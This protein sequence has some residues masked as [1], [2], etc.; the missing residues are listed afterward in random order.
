MKRLKHLFIAALCILSSC[1][2]KTQDDTQNLAGNWAFRLDSL[3]MGVNEKWYLDSLESTVTLPGSLNTNGIGDE[4]TKD[5]PWT[6]SIWNKVWYESDFYAKYRTPDNTKVVFW[7]TPDKYYVGAAWYQKEINIPENWKDQSVEL[8]LE[9]CHWETTLWVDS[10]EIGTQNTLSL[11]HRYYLEN[12]TAGKHILTL[13]VDNRTK[14]INPGADAHSISDN[15]QSNWNGIIGEI[16]INAVP[17]TRI[18]NVRIEPLFDQKKIKVQYDITS[19]K[20]TQGTLTLAVNPVDRNGKKL[21]KFAQTVS[22]DTAN[23]IEVVY[24]MTDDFER[25]D[26]FNPNLYTLESTLTTEFGSQTDNTQFG[27]RE[28]STKGTRI[29]VNNNPVFFRGTLECCIFPKTG[30]PPTDEDEWERIMNICKDYGL[31]HIRFHSWCPPTAAF[32]VADRLGMY[33]YVECGSWASDIGSGLGV[34]N[35]IMEESHRIVDE[36]GNHPSFCLFSYG[37]EPHGENR[38]AYLREFVKHWKAADNRFLYTT[39]AGWPEIEENDWQCVQAPRI[40]R[41]GEGVKSVI[42]G[43]EPS[44]MYDWSEIISKT[45]PTISHEI[46]QW[47]VYPNLK[48]REKYTGVFKAKNFDIFEDRLE[49]NGILHLADKFF[50]ASGKLQTLCYKADIE[51]ALRTEGQAGFQLL[52]LH[53]FPGQGSA[54][55][56]VVDPFWDS[57]PYVSAEEY[58]EFCNEVVPLARMERLVYNSLDTLTANIEVSQFSNS[59]LV[60]PKVKWSIVDTTEKCL[61]SGEFTPK[62]ITQGKLNSIGKISQ[63]LETDTPQQ[64]QLIVSVDNWINRWNIWLYPNEELPSKDILVT[65]KIDKALLS[66][67]KE[68]GSA[69]LTPKFGTLRNEGADSVVV[70]F[71][72]IFWNTMWTN[73]Q[74]PHTL[75]VLCDAA[76]P[77]LEL[78]PTRYHSDYQWRDAMSHCNAIPM[79]KLSGNIEP[80]VRIIDDWFTG[81]SLGMVV[82]MKV[83]KGK[84]IL[85]GVDLLSDKDSRPEAIQLKNSLLHYMQSDKFSPE[86]EVTIE[87]LQNLF[88]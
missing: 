59:D 40:Q 45:H 14:D 4:V 76:S 77:A 42:N 24:D 82:E 78:F 23:H 55:V 67:I 19:S 25:W 74:P 71:S 66:R 50:M 84:I 26:E 12:L 6:G 73:G 49:D 10:L 8:F 63:Q 81:R 16:S 31:N 87:E 53:D 18:N 41:W 64:L 52:D 32:N 38:T 39:G 79:H 27:I 70:G 62:V 21:E 80:T 88:K 58:S 54:L 75:G 68:G 72:S 36:Y 11:P 7:L 5:T 56:G 20:A 47:C 13:R 3:D 46:G 86:G 83:G 51:A 35:Y 9:R 65:D 43:K 28:L 37:N 69:L 15:T 17:K 29:Y 30:F 1:S 22:I 34:D 57:K 60:N 44:T 2:S 61:Y 33:L 48:E 85:C